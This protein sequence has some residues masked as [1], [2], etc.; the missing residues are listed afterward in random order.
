MSLDGNTFQD[1]VVT[2]DKEYIVGD[3]LIGLCFGIYNFEITASHVE[4]SKEFQTQ[5]RD[6][7]FD[8]LQIRWEF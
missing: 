8:S 3:G 7:R 5:E 6:A 4:K 1:N 2:V